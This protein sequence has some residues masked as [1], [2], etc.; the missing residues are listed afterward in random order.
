VGFDVILAT[1]ER[2]VS[3]VFLPGGPEGK[4]RVVKAS[5]EGANL[6]TRGLGTSLRKC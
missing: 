4:T 1:P 5:I 2:A 3:R 6:R